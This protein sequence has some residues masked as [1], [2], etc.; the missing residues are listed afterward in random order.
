MPISQIVTNSIA[1]NAVSAAKLASDASPAQIFKPAITSPANNATGVND[2]DT[3]TATSYFSLYGRSQANAQWQL[4]T[5]PSFA[6]INVSSTITGSNSQFTLNTSSG[7]VTNTLY[8]AR[9][10]YSDDA[11]NSSEYSNT[12]QFT[13]NTSFPVIVDFL[14]VAGGGGGSTSG[15]GAG[16]YRTSFGT[17][18]G[19]ASAEST[20]AVAANTNVTVTVGAGGS[21][22]IWP[23][24]YD[25]GPL[26]GSNSVFASVTSIGGGG[27]GHSGGG[28]HPGGSGGGGSGGSAPYAGGSGTPGQ[29]YAGGSAAAVDSYASGG[30]GGAGTLGGDFIGSRSGGTAGSGGA[31][32]TSTI[33]GSPVAR[34]GGGGA[35]AAAYYSQSLGTTSAG[36]GAGGSGGGGGTAGSPNTGGGGGGGA[37]SG[38][39][40][41]IGAGA[42]GGSGIVIL[43][44]PTAATI[45]NPGGGLTLSTSTSVPGY[46]I[47]S[48]TA[49][50]GNVS[51]SKS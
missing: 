48:V 34:A 16:G 3:I 36:G 25:P 29:G 46:K 31:G 4:S 21:G 32:V 10:R 11:N 43:R 50:T 45:S 49:G 5:S 13:S 9:V 19:G 23:A 7:L 30:G 41:T 37:L 35:A 42:A 2:N 24:D 39:G 8:Y 38:P 47:T 17:S 27:G 33:T 51:W 44:Y 6:F 1:N 26:K 20:A 15:G 40:Q 12:V 28:G 18:G 22:W 14:V